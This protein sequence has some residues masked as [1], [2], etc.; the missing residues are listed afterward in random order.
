MKVACPV[1]RKA[2]DFTS[3]RDW[4]SILR[5]DTMTLEQSGAGANYLV[6]LLWRSA[7]RSMIGPVSLLSRRDREKKLQDEL[8]PWMIDTR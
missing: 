3:E 2:V 6:I 8:F 4:Q 7:E 1:W 5:G